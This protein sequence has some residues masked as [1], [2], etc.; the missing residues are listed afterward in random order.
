MGCIEEVETVNQKLEQQLSEKD[1]E[2]QKLTERLQTLE[3]KPPAIDSKSQV[4]RNLSSIGYLAAGIAHNISNPLTVIS[5]RAQ[6]LKMKMP[7]VKDFEIIVTEARK[8]ESILSAMV[9]KSEQE[10][11]TG[12]KGLDL[13]R[14]MTTE[15]DFLEAD[16]FFK[17]KIQKDIRIPERLPVVQGV[18][19]HFSQLFQGI[20]HFSMDSMRESAQKQLTISIRVD[21]YI[22]IILTDTGIGY[23]KTQIEKLLNQPWLEV[24]GDAS[25]EETFY[26]DLYETNRIAKSYGAEILISSRKGR[27]SS[28]TLKIPFEGRL[29]S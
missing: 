8:V 1:R 19:S 10:Q 16:S 5:A 2:I 21:D 6:L 17:H 7:G 27:G 18:Y 11:D 9:Q 13:S 25:V 20:I 15:L 24:S 23:S 4:Q 3:G 12:R 26:V 28:I 14:L 29:V 22:S